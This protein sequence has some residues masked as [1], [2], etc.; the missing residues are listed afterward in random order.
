MHPSTVSRVLNDHAT[1]SVTWGAFAPE[2]RQRV[3]AAA[4]RLGYRPSA[5]ARSLRLQRTLTLG[6]LVPDIR[7]PFFSSIIKGAE[8]AALER[9]Y[10]IIL[11]NSNDEPQREASYLRVLR[12]RQVDGLLIASSQMADDTIA[13]LREEAFPFV[14]LNRATRSTEDLAVVVDNHAAAVEVVGHLAALGHRR[15]GHIAGPQN[16]TTGVDRREGY[17]A[18][19]L[20]YGLDDEPQLVIEADA[21]SEEAGQRALRIILAGPA[22]PTAV[23]AANDLVA[24]GVMATLEEAGVRVPDEVSIVGFDN[25]ALAGLRHVA[26]TTVDQ[27][28]P[29][30]G[31]AAL[32]SLHQRTSGA[33]RDPT[34]VLARPRLVARRSTAAPRPT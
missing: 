33:R 17:R 2:T 18:G 26:L 9:G 31:R 23:F 8:D 32:T 3:L 11:C 29:E 25:T 4:D 28:C 12:E 24:I 1:A 15:V 19:V 20:A 34:V 22:R 10:N 6:M 16:T 27:S 21:F 13:E 14:L 30:M 7:N 5:I